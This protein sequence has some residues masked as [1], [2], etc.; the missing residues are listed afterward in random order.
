MTK[1]QLQRFSQEEL[2]DFIL[3]WQTLL[4]HP[5][6]ELADQKRAQNRQKRTS[7]RKS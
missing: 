7:R 6:A 4:H 5:L 2:I 3:N 1:Q